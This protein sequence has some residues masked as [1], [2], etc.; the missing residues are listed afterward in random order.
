METLIGSFLAV[1]FFLA[2][3]GLKLDREYQ[4]GVIF[5]LGRIQGVR[6]SGLYGC[7]AKISGKQVVYSL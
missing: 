7:V 4:R 6:G 1:S 3:A 2:A 5:R